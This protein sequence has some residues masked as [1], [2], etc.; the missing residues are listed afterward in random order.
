MQVSVLTAIS[1]IVS[2]ISNPSSLTSLHRS[3]LVGKETFKACS[4]FGNLEI[5]TDPTGLNSDCLVDADALTAIASSLPQNTTIDLIEKPNKIEW[6]CGQAKG[7][8]NLVQTDHAIPNISHQTFPWIPEKNL[9]DA[10]LLSSCA[11]QAA[12]VA[13][14]LYGI[15]IEPSGNDL[16]LTSSNS[17]ALASATI[18]KGSYPFSKITLR[19]PVPSIISALIQSCP[20]CV[21]DVT[22][23]GIFISGDWLRA[24]LPLG[25][26]LTHDLKKI[27]DKYAT[28]THS[29][30]ID[31]ASV[32]RFIM[33]AKGLSDKHLSFTVGLRIEQGKLALTH[34]G[35]SSGSE[36]F[37]LAD[38]L[39]TSLNYSSVSLP[40]DMLVVPLSVIETAVFDYLPQQQIVLRGSNPN[41]LY[42]VGGG[43]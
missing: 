5:Q 9:G 38:G 8:L 34:S 36:E 29:A 7:H 43:D 6:K 1:K 37:F 32:R 19:P 41:F 13:V 15:T 35:I 31:N 25:T 28:S 18:E 11:C 27:A 10:L 40:A 21:L 20:N 2:K 26:N 14:G 16:V 24:Q 17:I 3:I 12:A 4:E 42:V 39:D 33:R 23:E 22:S 30:K